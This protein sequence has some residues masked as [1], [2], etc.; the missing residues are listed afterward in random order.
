MTGPRRRYSLTSVAIPRALPLPGGI[1]I[2]IAE[3]IPENEPA[4]HNARGTFF[5]VEPDRRELIEIA[6][7]I[8]TQVLEPV[9]ARIVPL[10]RAREAF[11]ERSKGQT[12]G[13][14]VLQVRT[15]QDD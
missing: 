1:L 2:S 14:I 13:K 8:D 15:E 5:I 6:H 12:R 11:E 4:H 3:P 9:V 7:L 10:E